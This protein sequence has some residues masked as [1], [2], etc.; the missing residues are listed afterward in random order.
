MHKENHPMYDLLLSIKAYQLMSVGAERY[1]GTLYSTPAYVNY[2]SFDFAGE[3]N[4]TYSLKKLE[5]RNT[6]R[7]HTG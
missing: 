7:K 2:I 4:Y 6:G 3:I 1:N 5:V